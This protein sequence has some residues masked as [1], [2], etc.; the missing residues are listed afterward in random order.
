MS[1]DTTGPGVVAS[2]FTT[3][4][5]LGTASPLLRVGKVSAYDRPLPLATPCRRTVGTKQVPVEDN[6]R[7]ARNVVALVGS[8]KMW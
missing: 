3:A 5:P 6:H 1:W 2:F 4:C 8:M 7:T